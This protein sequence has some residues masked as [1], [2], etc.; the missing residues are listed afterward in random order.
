MQ[1][2]SELLTRL[3]WIS[4]PS[5]A[6]VRVVFEAN[7]FAMQSI[8]RTRRSA[9]APTIC[10]GVVMSEPIGPKAVLDMPIGSFGRPTIA[11]ACGPTGWNRER[12]G[13]RNTVGGW[14]QKHT[15]AAGSRWPCEIGRPCGPHWL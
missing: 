3:L 6:A 1:L 7:L 9:W 4:R 12:S 14:E 15:T 5:L 11:K 10:S 13:T 2:A 8:A